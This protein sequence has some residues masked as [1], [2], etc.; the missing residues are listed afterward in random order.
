[1]CQKIYFTQM[2]ETEF[3]PLLERS[4]Y[5]YY[6]DLRISKRFNHEDEIYT[7]LDRYKKLFNKG[8]DS[9]NFYFYNI[10][11]MENC[12]IGYI[13]FKLLENN[14]IY[15]YDFSIFE[16]FRNHGYG[17]KSLILF[18]NMLLSHGIEEIT[19]HV[20]NHNKNALKLYKKLKYIPI[21]H[22]IGGVRMKK[23]L[24]ESHCK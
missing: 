13:W 15:I 14:C 11:E 23:T 3:K 2:K 7:E 24:I 22:E 12:P 5:E 6:F 21:G 1:M 10:L 19:F 17:Y 18:E 9:A 4:L 16:Q 8:V 20:F